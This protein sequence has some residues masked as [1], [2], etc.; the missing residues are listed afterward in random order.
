M[1]FIETSETKNNG[2]NDSSVNKNY[3]EIIPKPL[4]VMIR[5]NFDKEL[6]DFVSNNLSN[7]TIFLNGR[8]LRAM[9]NSARHAVRNKIW[10]TINP[11]LRERLYSG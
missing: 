1:K 4:K 8:I 3:A 11:F 5:G 10:S 2:N 9:K 6:S 7:F